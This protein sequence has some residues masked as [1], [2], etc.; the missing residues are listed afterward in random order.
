MKSNKKY[1]QISADSWTIRNMFILFYSFVLEN[2]I[3]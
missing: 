3:A 1:S 2:I